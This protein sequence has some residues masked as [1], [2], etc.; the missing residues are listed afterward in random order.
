M[1]NCIYKYKGKDYTK[2]EFY[3]LVSSSNFIQQEQVK[4]FTELQERLNNKEFLEGAKNAFESSEELQRFGTQEQYNDYIAR[5]S[6]GIVKNPSSGEYNHESQVKDIVYHGANEPIEGEKFVVRQG[7]TGNGI[8]FSGSK[9]YATNVMNRAPQPESLSGRKLRGDAT[10]YSVLLN[11]K[12]PAHFYESSGAILAQSSERFLEGQIEPHRLHGNKQYDKNV[13]DGALFHHPNSKKPET[14]DSAEQVVVF[15][16]EQIH[17]LGSKQDVQ[18]FKEFAANQQNIFNQ[19]TTEQDDVLPNDISFERVEAVSN[20]IMNKLAILGRPL[21]KRDFNKAKVDIF[22]KNDTAIKNALYMQMLTN[23]FD[24][25]F[26]SRVEGADPDAALESI[27]NE[28]LK[29]RFKSRLEELTNNNP[30]VKNKEALTELKQNY[31]LLES[32][33]KH[34]DVE[35]INK[36]DEE[37]QKVIRLYLPEIYSPTKS[38]K[39]KT[40]KQKLIFLGNM[41]LKKMHAK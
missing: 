13:N 9:R 2:E 19:R 41:M 35:A 29:E 21:T 25:S 12:N 10:M 24:S 7:A 26:A 22:Y 17:I 34:K 27:L 31:R 14:S 1:A 33:M 23:I 30:Y 38:M 11:I 18:G 32:F 6:L 36:Y 16:P 28:D 3:S 5:V 39:F 37:Q 20:M 15:E 40:E 8:W 4:K